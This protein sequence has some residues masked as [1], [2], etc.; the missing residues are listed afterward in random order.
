MKAKA[1]TVKIEHVAGAICAT[2]KRTDGERKYFVSHASAR[3]LAHTTHN[4]SICRWSLGNGW[5][6]NLETS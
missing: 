1:Y 5:Y 3:R 4:I 2:I 6:A